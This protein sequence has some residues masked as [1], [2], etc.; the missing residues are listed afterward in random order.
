MVKVITEKCPQ[1]H[2]CPL[3]KV[4]PVGAIIQKNFNAPKIDES[5]CIKCLK[6]VEMCPHKAFSK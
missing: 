2:R 3:I 1:D 4:C 6:C 5:K